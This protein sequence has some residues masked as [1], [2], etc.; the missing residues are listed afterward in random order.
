MP[1]RYTRSLNNLANGAVNTFTGALPGRLPT[2]AE[3][4]QQYYSG[5]ARAINWTAKKN[6]LDMNDP[7]EAAQAQFMVQRAMTSARNTSASVGNLTMGHLNR[8]G[9]SPSTGDYASTAVR[10]IRTGRSKQNKFS[11]RNL[12]GLPGKPDDPDQPGLPPGKVP[13]GLPPGPPAPPA[14]GT[15]DRPRLPK[16]G[17]PELEEPIYDGVLVDPPELGPGPKGLPS[18]EYIDVE[19][20]MDGEIPELGPKG[21]STTGAPPGTMLALPP[22]PQARDDDGAFPMPP[23]PASPAQSGRRTRKPYDPKRPFV[24]GVPGQVDAVMEP[25]TPTDMAAAVKNQ[26]VLGPQEINHLPRPPKNYRFP[27]SG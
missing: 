1:N 19:G 25:M 24:P 8:P 13:P 6:G 9:W 5:R 7:A 22:G 4:A 15:P 17:R 27:K 10:G 21:S 12:Y 3:I 20:W 18:G 26:S 2:G 16:D 11:Q 14:I 23:A